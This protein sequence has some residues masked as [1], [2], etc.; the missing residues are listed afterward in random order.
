MPFCRLRS[1]GLGLALLAAALGAGCG[2]ERNP[3]ATLAETDEPQYQSGEQ[4]LKEE[5]PDEALTAFL[6]VIKARA[7]DAPESHLEAGRIYLTNKK[8]PISAI[9]HFKAYLAAKPNSDQAPMV[10]ELINT[11]QKN[12]AGS[13]PGEPHLYDEVELV[14]EIASLKAENEKLRHEL[15]DGSISQLTGSHLENMPPA[16]SLGAN[17]VSTNSNVSAPP[18]TIRPPAPTPTPT[19]VTVTAAP[20]PP[21]AASGRTYTVASGDTLSSISLKIFGTRSRWQEIYNL[22]RD[23]LPKPDSTLHIGQVLKLPAQ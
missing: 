10:K 1:A 4:L 9:Y 17:S 21:V 7:D 22:N 5:H 8:D 11:A 12:Y 16:T 23:Q 3:V 2:Q 15:E 20:V 18:A 13:L 14:D 6:G 19:P